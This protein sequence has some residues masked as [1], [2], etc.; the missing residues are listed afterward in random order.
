[1]DAGVGDGHHCHRVQ[2][3]LS[4]LHREVNVDLFRSRRADV[5]LKRRREACPKWRT[6]E[7]GREDGKGHLSVEL[8]VLVEGVVE[9]LRT[10][11]QP[12]GKG[13]FGTCG[14]LALLKV[15]FF[16]QGSKIFRWTTENSFNRNKTPLSGF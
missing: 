8:G 4:R 6:G 7:E 1:M 11:L 16:K 9:L 10:L 3:L 12:Q 13:R 5:T 14:P 2:L 15:A